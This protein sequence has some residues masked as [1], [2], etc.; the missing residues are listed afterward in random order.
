MSPWNGRNTNKKVLPSRSFNRPFGW[1]EWRFNRVLGMEL[2]T[3]EVYSVISVPKLSLEYQHA[4]NLLCLLP[5]LQLVP[6]RDC[7]F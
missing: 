7:R 5:T 3:S 1:S 6:G 2:N 4:Q